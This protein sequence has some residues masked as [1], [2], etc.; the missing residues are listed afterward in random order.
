MAILL[1][2]ALLTACGGEETEG[3]GRPQQGPMQVQVR[4]LHARA[5]HNTIQATGSLMANEAI[6]V[7]SETA[8]RVTA[9]GFQEGGNVA[10]GQ[11]LLR[12]NDDDLQ[13][14]LK[15]AELGVQLATDDEARKKQLLAVK[16]LSQQAYDDASIALKSAEADRDNLRALI[17]KTVIRAPFSGKIGLRQV[18]LGGYVSPNTLITDLQ[19]VSPIKVDFTVP[20]R[21]GR[22]LAPGKKV[23]FTLDG[24]TTHYA[25]EI[26]AVDPGVDPATRTIGA[27]ARTTDPDGRLRP[28]AFAHITV[29]LGQVPQALLIPTE[30]LIPDIQGQKVLLIRNGKAASARVQTGIRTNTEVEL[31]GGVQPGDTVIVT[32][33]LQVRDGMSV[34]AAPAVAGTGA[35]APDSTAAPARA[36]GKP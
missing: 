4:V 32:G 18:S 13:A 3:N 25:A 12:I 5:L 9:I 35:L 1:P 24:D 30:A 27:R 20:E 17:A 7:R 19:Q 29:E 16:G 22:E 10:Q 14:Q 28:G 11:V 26:Y 31:I 33:L 6:E 34:K 2:A 23:Q 15:K 36:T 8:G 21:Y